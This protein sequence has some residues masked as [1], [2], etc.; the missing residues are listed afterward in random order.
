MEEY[1]ELIN[2]VSDILNKAEMIKDNNE[3]QSFLEKNIDTFNNFKNSLNI[4][5]KEFQFK[6]KDNK[7]QNA[8]ADKV[9]NNIVRLLN[10]NNIFEKDEQYPYFKCELIESLS[11]NENNFVFK[12]QNEADMSKVESALR[13]LQDRQ[14]YIEVL[15]ANNLFEGQD[16]ND[17]AAK[18]YVSNEYEQN[19]F[20][21]ALMTLKKNFLSLSK[22]EVVKLLEHIDNSTFFKQ[23]ISKDDNQMNFYEKNLIYQYCETILKM[24]SI[25]TPDKLKYDEVIKQFWNGKIEDS[26]NLKNILENISVNLFVDLLADEQDKFEDGFLMDIANHLKKVNLSDKS[27]SFIMKKIFDLQAVS[28]EYA[29]FLAQIDLPNDYDEFLDSSYSNKFKWLRDLKTFNSLKDCEKSIEDARRPF[30]PAEYYIK[31]LDQYNKNPNINEHFIENLITLI[32]SDYYSQDEKNQLTD[33]LK[34][35]GLYNEEYIK[36]ETTIFDEKDTFEDTKEKVKQAYYS[37]Q[38]IPIG[39]AQKI[40]NSDLSE[41]EFIDKTILQACVQG[42]ICNTLQSKGINIGNK[43]FF[44]NGHGRNLGYNDSGHKA[45]WIDDVLLN[46]YLRGKTLSDKAQLFETMFHEMQHAIQNHNIQNNQIDYLTYNFIKERIIETYDEDF[47]SKNY[48]SIFMESDARKGGILGT[49][50]FLNG[51]NP[52]FVKRIRENMERK[53]IFESKKYTLYTDAAKKISIGK[54]NLID[55]SEYVGLLIQNNPNILSENPILDIEYNANGTKKD[56]ETLLNEF[57][58]R[59]TESSLGYEN[60][61]SIY[62]GLVAKEKERILPENTDLLKK[63]DIFMQEEELITVEDMQRY[64]HSVDKAAMNELYS[65]LYSITRSKDDISK[66]DDRHDNIK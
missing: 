49:V 24:K 48:I 59:K 35:N 8:M 29:Q 39:V 16:L 66:G 55:I 3:R 2:S 41:Q 17:S 6:Q 65:R 12:L 21:H 27:I 31:K 44:G 50:E 52:Y 37:R 14:D 57:E 19:L 9:K 64:Y 61:Y 56:I 58:Q 63:I 10:I 11:W 60:L 43:V 1:I 23:M 22:N 13:Y 5:L 34:R 62:Y 51:L 54:D 45:I 53:Y 38:V 30:L 26:K 47:Y 36:D 40:L 25:F 33:V 4:I 7:M 28:Y 32:H 18:Q 46:R 15:K 20:G 42:V